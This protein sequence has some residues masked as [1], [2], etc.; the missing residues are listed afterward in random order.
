MSV[1]RWISASIVNLQSLLPADLHYTTFCSGRTRT[2]ETPCAF[3]YNKSYLPVTSTKSN[4]LWRRRL[5][6]INGR[7][8]GLVLWT[9]VAP[10]RRPMDVKI[11]SSVKQNPLDVVWT[12]PPPDLPQGTFLRDISGRRLKLDFYTFQYRCQA[13]MWLCAFTHNA[14]VPC[15]ERDTAVTR[16][17]N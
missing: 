10:L 12:H 2:S 15:T 9:L 4:N 6:R 13:R 5:S 14:S 7:S 11:S 17:L 8:V 16:A 3:V 1:N